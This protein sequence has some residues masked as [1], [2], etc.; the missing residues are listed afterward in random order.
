MAIRVLGMAR[1]SDNGK[2]QV[3][4]ESDKDGKGQNTFNLAITELQAP[5]AKRLAQAYA[6]R[7]GGIPA[8]CCEFPG[9]PY[10][11][12]KEGKVVVDPVNQT[13]HR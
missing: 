10:P 12:D 13:I 4:L 5:D 6:Q 9:A 2:N 11:V 3:T 8:A 1:D 7:E